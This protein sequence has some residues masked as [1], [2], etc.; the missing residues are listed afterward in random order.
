MMW[1]RLLTTAMLLWAS[2]NC[3]ATP[4]WREYLASYRLLE[5][6]SFVQVEALHAKSLVIKEIDKSGQSEPQLFYSGLV[7]GAYSG[8]ATSPDMVGHAQRWIKSSPESMA[9]AIALGRFTVAW[10]QNGYDNL[11]SWAEQDRMVSDA[12]QQ[13]DRFKKPGNAHSEWHSV[14]ARIMALDGA[15]PSQVMERVKLHLQG[16]AMPGRQFFEDIVHALSLP[17]SNALPQLREL[18][19]LASQKSGKRDGL[20]MYA[21]VYITALDVHPAIRLNPFRSNVTDWKTLDA[22]ISDLQTHYPSYAQANYHAALSCLARDKA[23]ASVLLGPAAQPGANDTS[24]W[25]T[26]WGEGMYE[27]CKAW[28]LGESAPA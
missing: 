7:G 6:G 24:L 4:L 11:P 17:S 20:A 13:L 12:L 21:A 5:S 10:L 26:Y 23:R 8:G 28:A 25:K 2:G 14:Y 3:L 16:D 22:A 27:R 19:M 15:T 18:A 9:A 1:A